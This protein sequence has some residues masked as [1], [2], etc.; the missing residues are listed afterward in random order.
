MLRIQNT[1]QRTR[2][3][4][5]ELALWVAA[6]VALH[7]GLLLALPG[8]GPH[9]AAHV[10]I[11]SVTLARQEPPRV[12]EAPSPQPR[13]RLRAERVQREPPQKPARVAAPV[14]PAA[15]PAQAAPPRPV[16]AL[17]KPAGEPEAPFTAAP[18]PAATPGA[19]LA[20]RAEPAKAAPRA[21]AAK[22]APAAS[23][24]PEA[25]LTP[26][27]FNAGYLR[28]PPP[29][30]PLIARRNGEQGTVTLKVLVTREGL[31][32]NISVDT[33]SG[34]ANLDQ[35]A[36]EAVKS[37]RFAPARQGAQA[38]EA[39]VLVPIVFRLEGVS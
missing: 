33:T 6:S 28:N 34:S 16:L 1:A 36:V 30:Y 21:D 38:V 20:L 25:K 9:D 19:D 22:N 13:E 39:W 24:P 29:R 7:A 27:N 12:L 31:P 3:R 5:R 37:W 8:K 32:A 11:L 15:A 18:S 23:P 14:E 2:A 26:P 17:P 35:A 4:V 10:E